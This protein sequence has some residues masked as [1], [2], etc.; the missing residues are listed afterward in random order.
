MTIESILEAVLYAS[1]QS[2]SIKKLSSV[3]DLDEDAIKLGLQRLQT[4]LQEQERGLALIL[5]EKNAELVTSAD[6][7]DAVRA[8]LEVEAQGELS[9]AAMEALAIIAYRGP[10]TRPELEQIRGIQSSMILRILAIRGLIEQK[11]E[12]RLGQPVYMVTSEFFK[13]MG[14]TSADQLPDYHSLRNHVSV[15]SALS[16]LEAPTQPSLTSTQHDS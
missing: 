13:H 6:A 3:L 8:V 4:Q 12:T 15:E 7:A 2:V 5:E 9:K 14:Y 10:I 11:E 16:E 1:G